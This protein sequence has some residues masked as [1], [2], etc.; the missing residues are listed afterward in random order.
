MYMCH[1]TLYTT[2]TLIQEKELPVIK[3]I[4]EA[5]VLLHLG[6]S[7]TTDHISPAGS[8]A[9]NSPAARY[10]F[11][12]GLVRPLPPRTLAVTHDPL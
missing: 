1:I 10:L 8:I 3:P 4:V 6:D 11:S 9:R 2:T 12:N 7:V 5:H